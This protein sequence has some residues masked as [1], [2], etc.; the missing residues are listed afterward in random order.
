M[1]AGLLFAFVWVVLV[2]GQSQLRELV[3]TFSSW[4]IFPCAHWV[5]CPLKYFAHFLRRPRFYVV[6]ILSFSK[7]LNM[8][9][10]VGVNV[11]SFRWRPVCQ[12]FPCYGLAFGVISKNLFA[13]PE[14]WRSHSLT[15]LAVLC[16]ILISACVPLF[17]FYFR[18]RSLLY[19]QGWTWTPS[20]PASAS[21]AW[22]L[23]VCTV[24][25]G[26]LFFWI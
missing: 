14:V 3:G 13:W 9:P 19:S 22:G 4:Q 24:T 16:F 26:E 8:G 12:L 21:Q 7:S 23:Q 6:D 15:A 1:S 10:L 17:W 11:L 20:S 5:G 25:A 2:D 18:D